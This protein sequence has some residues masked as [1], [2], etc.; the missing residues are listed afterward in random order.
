M[1]RRLL[2]VIQLLLLCFYVRGETEKSSV[3]FEEGFHTTGYIYDKTVEIVSSGGPTT[4]FWLPENLSKISPIIQLGPKQNISG[5][6]TA[7]LRA[8]NK[9]HMESTYQT[10]DKN[11]VA[12]PDETFKFYA[13]FPLLMNKPGLVYKI[14]G[15]G[16]GE[17]YPVNTV[18]GLACSGNGWTNFT[19]TWVDATGSPIPSEKRTSEYKDRY[20]ITRLLNVSADGHDAAFGCQMMGPHF[21]APFTRWFNFTR[22]DNT[23]GK[24]EVDTSICG[25]VTFSC[26]DS[27]SEPEKVIIDS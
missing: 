2:L 3:L 11:I 5:L 27:D 10:L 9:G 21:K 16:T 4:H 6:G 18:F 8:I 23:Q 20:F 19:L 24:A 13:M 1:F 25:Q 15:F 7:L 17:R 22:I 26:V 14:L 12:K